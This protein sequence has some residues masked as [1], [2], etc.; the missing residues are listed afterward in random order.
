[1]KMN[2]REIEAIMSLAKKILEEQDKN[3]ATDKIIRASEDSHD[4]FVQP[5]VGNCECCDD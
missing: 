5:R 1:M 2:K 3:L 4:S